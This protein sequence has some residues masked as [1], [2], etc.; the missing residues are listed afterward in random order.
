M[1]LAWPRGATAHTP[2]AVMALDDPATYAR[3]DPRGFRD[4][5]RGFP[6]QVRQAARLA[7]GVRLARSAPGSVL[8]AGM[9]GSA[10]AGEM[11]E[12][13]GRARARL[14][15]QVSR[16]YDLPAWVGP[17][18]LV[19]AVSYS[20]D[21]EETL[22]AFRQARA[23]G[24]QA[25]V[26]A[27]G[28]ELGAGAAR[29]G[30]PWIRVPRG[31]PPRAALP[32]LLVPLLVLL[33]D[34]GVMPCGPGERAEAVAVLTALGGELEP[35]VPLREN[36]AKALAA[37]LDRRTP[38]IYGTDLTAPAASRWR[39]QM[40]ENAKVLA[41]SGVLPEMNHNAIEAW[42][43]GVVGSWAVILLRDPVD[44]PRVARRAELTRATTG[45]RAPTREAWARG[46]GHLARLLS[47]VLLG[48]WVSYYV[49]ILRGVDPWMVPTLDSFKRRMAEADAAN[50]PSAPAKP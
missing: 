9:G 23:R 5:L 39:T 1:R 22:A 44:H 27:S 49:A 47:L 6:E 42:G 14:P 18:V 26:V 45:M 15:L 36:P 28:G 33:H 11:L 34:A 24:A 41:L 10:A 30:L 25:L 12:A 40:E 4:L 13:L 46:H 32:S 29:D 17:A 35:G 3:V 16:G 21:T 37:W 43:A 20:G 50:A 8:I 19:V 7:D 31:F 2:A 38:V 48:D